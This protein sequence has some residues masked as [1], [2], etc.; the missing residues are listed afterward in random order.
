MSHKSKGSNAERDLIHRFWEAGW[1]AMRAAGSGSAR[2]PSPDVI[3]GK[4][5]R[6]LVIECKVT[7][8]AKKYIDR[9][10][11]DE[12]LTFASIMKAEAWLAVKFPKRAWIFVSV[13]DAIQK[14]K[15]VM[16]DASMNEM[17]GYGF[18]EL[19]A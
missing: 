13:H 16:V 11:I 17:Q 18:D 1:A 6:I 4:D 15:S 19:I 3:A 2:T 7:I 9:R 5:G 8:G 10:E 14:G 12:L